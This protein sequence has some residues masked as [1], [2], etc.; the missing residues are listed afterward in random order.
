M[1]QPFIGQIQ[2]FAFDFPPRNWALC[3]GQLLPIN[4]NQALF[5]LLGTTYGGN[6]TTNFALPDL[7][8]RAPVHSG[9]GPGLPAVSLGEKAGVESVTLIATQLPAHSHT[10]VASSAAPT[11]G[12]VTS[13]AWATGGAA[14]YGNPPNSVMDAAALAT[15]GGNQPHPNMQPS[16]VVNFCIALAGIFP[17]RN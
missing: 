8:G 3:A 2:I 5:S 7:R 9:T 15:T 4:Q 10:P 16:L 12:A 11:V 6:G 14:P 1:S 13:N 17:S